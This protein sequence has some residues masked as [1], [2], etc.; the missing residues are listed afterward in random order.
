MACKK[1]PKSDSLTSKL[2]MQ[3]LA[4]GRPEFD[5]QTYQHSV[6]P[7]APASDLG[8]QSQ[9]GQLLNL[10]SKPHKQKAFHQISFV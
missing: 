9:P 4:Y 1:F 6:M 5:P 7:G 10:K 3:I 2:N 8:V